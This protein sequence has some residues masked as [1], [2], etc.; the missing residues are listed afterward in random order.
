MDTK[1]ILS[2]IESSNEFKEFKEEHKDFYLTHFFTMLTENGQSPWQAGYYS[3]KADK[4]VVFELGDEVI[5]HEEEDVFKKKKFV[6]QL[7]IESLIS[8]E[9]ALKKADDYKQ[10]NYPKEI[11][12]QRIVILQNIEEGIVWNITI[13]S[14][15]LN[16]LNLK[17]RASDGH[18]LK[19]SFD[20]ILR[21]GKN[22]L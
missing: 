6:K 19:H 15:Q 17:I 22:K 14:M 20:S 21:L 11:E 13:I 4:I 18:I 10:E 1:E 8:F 2:K 7:K 12:K 3:K 16:M 9:N 5:R